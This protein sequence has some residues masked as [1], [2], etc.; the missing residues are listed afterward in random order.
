MSDAAS[1]ATQASVRVVV[2]VVATVAISACTGG[3]DGTV[4]STTAATSAPT[5]TTTVSDVP[6]DTGRAF[7]MAFTDATVETSSVASGDAAHY[8]D[9][10]RLAAKVLGEVLVALPGQSEHRICAAGECAVLGDIETDPRDGLV[11]TFSV[12]GRPI[13]ERIAGSGLIADDDGVVAQTRTAYVTNASQLAVTVEIS[14]TTDTDVELFG[15][16]AVLQP[17]DG[18]SGVEAAGS[19]GDPQVTSGADALL[20]FVFDTDQ[21]GGR[22]G[23]RGLR[24]DGLDIALE[25]D[26]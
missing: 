13:A 5:T 9:H 3:D 2:V 11:T 15:F 4:P 14:N 16:A 25:I 6:L 10:R 17:A 20:L 1:G 21:L 19:W 18:S 22:V 23:L 24:D 8:L 26:V 12:D 7:V